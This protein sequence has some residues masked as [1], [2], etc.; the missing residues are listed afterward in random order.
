M[1]KLKQTDRDYIYDNLIDVQWIVDDLVEKMWEDEV[2]EDEIKKREKDEAFVFIM[3]F[4]FWIM[5][6]IFIL[7]L[8]NMSS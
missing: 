7:G 6:T 8:I 4:V 2:D 5:V 1:K 3:W